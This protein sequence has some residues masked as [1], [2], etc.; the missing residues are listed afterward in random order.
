MVIFDESGGVV[1]SPDLD[2]GE[3]T[4]EVEPVTHS[5]VVDSEEVGHWE[6][7]AEY[8]NGGRDV[9]WVVDSPETGHWDTKDEN[10]EEVEHFDGAIAEDWPKDQTI[11]DQWIYG[12]YRKYTEDELA[13]IAKEKAEAERQSQIDELKRKLTESDYVITK[14]SE[15][16]ASGESLSD[17]DAQRYADVIAQRQEWRSQI[18]ELEAQDESQ[19]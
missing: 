10:G 13:K 14:I 16:N 15:Y 17:E 2:L 1:E 3:V 8:D 9:E 6:T 11:S 5:W 12:T 18:N 19:G 7:V 4:Y